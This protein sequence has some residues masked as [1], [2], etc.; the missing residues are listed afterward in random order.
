ELFANNGDR[1]PVI[2]IEHH[3]A[4]QRRRVLARPVLKRLFNEITQRH[5]H[6]PQIPKLDGHIGGADFF[7]RAVFALYDH[8]IVQTDWL[9]HRKLHSGQQ[10][11][12]YRSRR[13]TGG[14]AGNSSGS[15]QADAVLTNRGDRHQGGADRHQQDDAVDDA[16][17][18]PDLRV[19]L[20]REEVVIGVATIASKGG[21][22]GKLEYEYCCPA[23]QADDSHQQ[24]P[25]QYFRRF[26]VERRDRDNDDHS[27][28]YQRQLRE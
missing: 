26:R 17:Q 27:Q 20:T 2:D 10:I 16:Q 1:R 12:Q 28:R 21:R 19:V 13:Q 11:A 14:D 4:D 18:D 23:D 25:R 8:G 9:R 24:Q 3:A 7:N 15:N 6:A 22:R 5:D